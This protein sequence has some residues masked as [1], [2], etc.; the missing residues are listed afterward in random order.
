MSEWPVS[1]SGSEAIPDLFPKVPIS[2]SKSEVA[3][4]LL[5]RNFL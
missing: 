5:P 2:R 1:R 4:S 3:P